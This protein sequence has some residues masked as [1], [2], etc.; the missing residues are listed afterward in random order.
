MLRRLCPSSVLAMKILPLAPCLL[1]FFLFLANGSASACKPGEYFNAQFP[2]GA[3]RLSGTEAGKL[4]AWAAKLKQ[5]PKH[6]LFVLVGYVDENN[7]DESL[8]ERRAK[9]VKDFLIEMG[10]EG[11]RVAYGGAETYKRER[12][13]KYSSIKTSTIAID[14]LP[15]CPNGCCTAD[16]KPTIVPIE[17][18]TK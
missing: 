8:A 2:E 1:A 5:Y 16:G 17:P 10:E 13:G 15:G 3:D 4:G 7:P 6:D 12:I 14:F 9:W 18:S 11:K